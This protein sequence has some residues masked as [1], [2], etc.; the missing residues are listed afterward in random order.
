MKLYPGS[1]SVTSVLVVLLVASPGTQVAAQEGALADAVELFDRQD[2]EGSRRVLEGLSEEVGADGEALY[3]LGRLALIDGRPEEAAECFEKAIDVDPEKSE[4]HYWL[5]SA[6]VRRTPYRNFLGRI[7]GS[8]KALKEFRKAIE[9]DPANL[10]A[11]ANLFQM[12]VRS[13]GMPGVNEEDLR[14]QAKSIAGID[15]I[16]GLVAWGTFFQLVENDMGQAGEHF[17]RAYALAPTN[18]PAAISYAD[19]LWE[20]DRRDEAIEVLGSFVEGDPDDKPAHFNMATRLILGG[21]AYA[22]ARDLFEHCLG[23]KSDTGMPSEAMVRWCLGLACHLLD[24]EDRAQA[25]WSMVY[26][27]DEDFDRL[28]EA[29]PEMA[30]L[31][32]ILGGYSDR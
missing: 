20:I 25:E 14:D 19:Y 24:E 9:L 21:S 22:R 28:L 32:S 5:A 11:R 10:M 13:Y 27:L 1:V 30:Q 12:M 15:S 8:T 29:I 31:N 16:M 3:Y 26:V 17:E 4:Y 23:L 7:A 18:R 2:Y 6:L